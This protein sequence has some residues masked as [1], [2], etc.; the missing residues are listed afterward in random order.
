MALEETRRGDAP[1]RVKPTRL[2]RASPGPSKS[3]TRLF[4]HFV[5]L[6][7]LPRRITTMD[8]PIFYSR[9][10]YIETVSCYLGTGLKRRLTDRS[11]LPRTP[12]TKSHVERPLR[13]RKILFWVA[14]L[15]LL[16]VLSFAET[17]DELVPVIP[18]SYS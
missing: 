4:A 5:L 11:V 13:A 9:S 16:V 18:S 15:S 10:E 1:S 12:V 7:H 17:C 6:Q 3:P 2:S 14:R 8:A